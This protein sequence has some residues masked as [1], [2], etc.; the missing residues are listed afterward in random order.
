VLGCALAAAGFR[1]PIVS[2]AGAVPLAI[3]I[4][5]QNTVD[6]GAASLDFICKWHGKDVSLEQLRELTN[7][8]VTGTTMYDLRAAAQGIG[9]KVD[10]RECAYAALVAHLSSPGRYAVL[11]LSPSHF[12][13][14]VSSPVLG[15]IR[16]Y[17]PALGVYDLTASQLSTQARWAGAVLLLTED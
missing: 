8:T 3:R 12:A 13:A 14:A 5:N 7:T 11:H 9:F 15:R 4:E 1:L 6:C 17:D 16:L 2:D 10:A